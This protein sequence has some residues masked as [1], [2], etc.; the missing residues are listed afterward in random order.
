MQCPGVRGTRKSS[1]GKARTTLGEGAGVLGQHCCL[2]CVWA[3]NFHSYHTGTNSSLGVGG[4]VLIEEKKTSPFHTHH[5]SKVGQLD[6][7]AENPARGS[8]LG[9][10]HSGLP[11]GRC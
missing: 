10:L 9:S 7:V 8:F 2:Q 11:R 4:G 5:V 1:R 3:S 6:S